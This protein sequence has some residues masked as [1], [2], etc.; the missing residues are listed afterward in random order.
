MRL[1]SCNIVGFGKLKNLKIDFGKGM[2]A[3]QKENGW[4][5]T[6]FAVFLESMFYGLKPGTKRTKSDREKYAPWDGSPFGGFLSFETE[7]RVYQIERRFGKKE[8]EDQFA[9]YDGEGEPSE[10]YDANIGHSLFQVDRDSFEKSLYT[11]QNALPTGMTDS[12]NAKMNDL[13]S[14]KDDIDSFDQAIRRLEEAKK[15]M[16]RNTKNDPGRL[17]VVQQEIRTQ[18]EALKRRSAVADA[19]D[20]QRSVLE[21]KRAALHSCR[22]EKEDLMQQIAAWGEREQALGVFRGKKETYDKLLAEQKSMAEYFVGGIPTF[23][24]LEEMEEWARVLGVDENHWQALVNRLPSEEE[25]ER[26]R[27][28]FDSSSVTEE[29]LD[30]WDE[31]AK[32]ILALRLKCEHTAFPEEEKARLAELEAYFSKKHP[33]VEDLEDAMADASL[34][35]QYEGQVETLDEQYRNTKA[36]VSANNEEA[37][38][39]EQPRG[40]VYAIV[41]AGALACGAVA[42][43]WFLGNALGWTMAAVCVGM[44]VAVLGFVWAGERKSRAERMSRDKALSNELFEAKGAFEKKKKEMEA[45]REKCRDFLSGFL[46]SPTDTYPQMIGEVQRKKEA[47]DRLVER[48]KKILD[49]NSNTLEELSALQVEL[50]VMLSPY[51]ELY[52]MDLNERHEEGELVARLKEDYRLYVPMREALEEKEK[53]ER[54]MSEAKEILGEFLCRFSVGAA[55]DVVAMPERTAEQPDADGNEAAGEP[56]GSE[57]V[58]SEVLPEIR[59]KLMAYSEYESRLSALGQEIEEMEEQY[60]IDEEMM[61][62]MALQEKIFRVDERMSEINAQLQKAEES[63]SE[64]SEQWEEL[65]EV[66]ERLEALFEQEQEY[67]KKVHRYEQTIQYLTRTKEAF[68][69]RHMVAIRSSLSQYLSI[70]DLQLLE[71]KEGDPGFSLDYD[72]E[73]Q[74][75]RGGNMVDADRFSSGY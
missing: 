5:K 46:V 33:S 65:E 22:E 27:Q 21:E 64:L 20:K 63:E 71:T 66:S 6:T 59:Q 29:V 32:A 53:L 57:I 49:D 62:V 18:K 72:L 12:L 34:L 42:F 2:N 75:G 54:S 26:L 73:V 16:T 40:Q 41:A 51:A 19:L 36:R 24:E 50:Y 28:L 52:R 8:S 47:Y 25:E 1:L 48:E 37:S 7:G 14:A 43:G 11:P 56:A 58:I 60:R 45:Q 67:K 55:A 35:V 74:I 68:L 17:F 4:G 38:G 9:L 69:S 44:A 30:E 70:L 39:G 31:K 23:E 61:S 10:D 3:V 15:A 13:G